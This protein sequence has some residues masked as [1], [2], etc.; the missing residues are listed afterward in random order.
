MDFSITLTGCDSAYHTVDLRLED[1]NGR[2]LASL[3]A[4]NVTQHRAYTTPSQPAKYFLHVVNGYAGTA[5]SGC[6]YTFQVNPADAVLGS[7]PAPPIVAP[8][9]APPPAPTKPF[10]QY[11]TALSA[12][13]VGHRI[14][15]R[16]T[17]RSNSCVGI[18][19]VIL[20]R[21]GNAANIYHT[22]RTRSD[23]SFSM[24]LPKRRGRYYV[25]HKTKT[26]DFET[27]T[28]RCGYSSSGSVQR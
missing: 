25:V 8:P 1:I 27:E 11:S 3:G 7:L 26:W 6:S 19:R 16:L 23:G 28:V 15:G 17:S 22:T 5:A 21:V 13:R 20:K 2:A 10:Y 4:E 24:P 18:E 9:P 12:R 14:V